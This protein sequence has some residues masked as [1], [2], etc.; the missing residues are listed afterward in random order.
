MRAS[1]VSW[2]Q[3]I[4]DVSSEDIPLSKSLCNFVQK[5]WF[6]SP[7]CFYNVGE[8]KISLIQVLEAIIKMVDRSSFKGKAWVA[9]KYQRLYQKV[10]DKHG[11]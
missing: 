7:V 9:R 8:E 6:L 2:S 1:L 10:S 4:I 5:V 3:A 11:K